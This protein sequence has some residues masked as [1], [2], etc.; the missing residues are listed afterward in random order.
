M[1]AASRDQMSCA[2]RA[3]I[4]E[5]YHLHQQTQRLLTLVQEIATQ[6]DIAR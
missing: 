4:L 1:P 5:D 6:V 3:R 2:A